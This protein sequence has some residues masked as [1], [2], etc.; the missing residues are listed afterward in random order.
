MPFIA[1]IW[2]NL[3]GCLL[4]LLY[5]FGFERRKKCHKTRSQ[6][7]FEMVSLSEINLFVFCLFF[8]ISVFVFLSFCL[9]VSHLQDALYSVEQMKFLLI[10]LLE[11]LNAWRDHLIHILRFRIVTDLRTIKW[12]TNHISC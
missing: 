6:L 4:L 9:I 12:P 5:Y 3:L 10:E 7:N 8:S 2:N 1:V 11:K